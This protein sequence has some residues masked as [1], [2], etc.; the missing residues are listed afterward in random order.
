M[1]IPPDLNVYISALMFVLGAYIIALYVGM[2][3]WT[4]HDIRSRSRDL[5][6]Q[7]LATFLV[8]LFTVPGLLIYL[9]MRPQETL[10]EAYERDLTEE[11]IIQELEARRVCPNCKHGVESD[12]IVCPYCHQQL[13]LRCVGCG[14]LL[15]PEWD[16]CPY[17]GLFLEQEEGE[18]E[19][20]AV[21]EEPE[22]E[23]A[24]GELPGEEEL[25]P[26]P[27]PIAETVTTSEADAAVEE[28]TDEQQAPTSDEVALEEEELG[29]E[30][31]GAPEDDEDVKLPR[32]I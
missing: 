13:R 4:F 18:G 31:E 15:N 28:A 20:A 3:V 17:C 10:A 9:L 22:E 8:A 27:A 12:F 29:R 19:E 2:I 30:E 16:V 11:A 32:L 21:E 14:R 23:I 7:I 24:D 5:L 25:A 1:T 26:E 6:A